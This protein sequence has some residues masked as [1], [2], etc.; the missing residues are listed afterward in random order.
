MRI[1]ITA[2]ISLLLLS[3]LLLWKFDDRGI[4]QIHH[5]KTA[6]EAQKAEN[7][8][9][10]ERNSALEAEVNSLK[11]GL[12]AIEER[13]RAEMGMIGKGETFFY[14]LEETTTPASSKKIGKK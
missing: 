3:N 12:E 5:L 14:L 1:L 9:L 6:I 7:A 8:A 11:K 13:A 10:V 4:R 2:L